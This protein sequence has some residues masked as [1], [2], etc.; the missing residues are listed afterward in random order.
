MFIYN[1]ETRIFS[2]KTRLKRDFLV[3]YFWTLRNL[4]MFPKDNDDNTMID[5]IEILHHKENLILKLKEQI[6]HL[7][8]REYI[9]I[10]K[11]KQDRLNFGIREN[12]YIK[13]IHELEAEISE[14]SNYTHV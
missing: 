1:S 3:G 4:F 12:C 6:K 8:E 11:N 13:K 7:E 14:M 9:I 10:S 5:Y 2:S